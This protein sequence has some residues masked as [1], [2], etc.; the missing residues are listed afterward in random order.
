M[1]VLAANLFI[2]CFLLIYCY[3]QLL[4]ASSYFIKQGH[5]SETTDPCVFAVHTLEMK[6]LVECALHCGMNLLCNAF[7]FCFLDG[8]N[9]CRFRYGKANLLNTTTR[10]ERYEITDVSN[11]F[12]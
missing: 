7:D 11:F 1:K 5:V 3:G 6:S 8:F 9:T 12:V 10:C 2:H 4:P